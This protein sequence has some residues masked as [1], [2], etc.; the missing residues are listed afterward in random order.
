MICRR[1]EVWVEDPRRKGVFCASNQTLDALE[2]QSKSASRRC[3][4]STRRLHYLM[5]RRFERVLEVEGGRRGA[6]E[7]VE[8]RVAGAAAGE[9]L[10][11]REEDL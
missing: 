8:G 11:R 6:Q 7:T 10:S 1:C 3:F 9:R 5:S 4:L 2:K